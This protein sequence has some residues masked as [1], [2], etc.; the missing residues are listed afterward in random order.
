MKQMLSEWG[1]NPRYRTYLLTCWQE[2]DEVAG[3]VTW[4][5]GL[6]TPGDNRR[7]AFSTLKDGMTWI[8]SELHHE[9][10]ID[11]KGGN[12]NFKINSESV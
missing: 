2:R 9:T 12:P 5:F 8:E 4:R 11:E 7:R 1:K 3:T 10:R 6:E